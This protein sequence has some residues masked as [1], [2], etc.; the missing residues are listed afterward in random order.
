VVDDELVAFDAVSRRGLL[1]NASAAMVLTSIDGHSP[2]AEVVASLAAD[3]GVAADVLREDVDRAV[4]GF[5][6]W[7]LVEPV[8]PLAPFEVNDAP[9]ST[10]APDEG[11]E[12]GAG[13]V[14]AGAGLV[15]I[16]GSAE[17]VGLD[18]RSWLLVR[19]GLPVGGFDVCLRTDS[20]DVAALLPRFLTGFAVPSSQ[21]SARL[22]AGRPERDLTV[23]Q[24]E[25][26]E[27]F[28]IA[29]DGVVVDE[30][31]NAAAA[32]GAVLYRLDW[33]ASQVED[34]L[35]FH[36][37]AVERDGRV[38]LLAGFSGGGKST[39]TAAVTQRGWRYLSDEVASVD[40]ASLAVYPFPKDLDLGDSGFEQLGVTGGADLGERKRKLPPSE[41]GAV[42]DGGELSL[43]V[44]LDEQPLFAAPGRAGVV[45]L[46]PAEAMVALM[47]LVFEPSLTNDGNLDALAELCERVPVV[48]L[49]RASL[50]AMVDTIEDLLLT[51]LGPVL[52]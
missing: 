42:S 49:G 50:P 51:D 47:P 31:P 39:L 26:G 22:A 43:V 1:L 36:S 2:L 24:P 30:A 34:L 44:L 41:L 21:G 9:S 11:S 16:G 17:L 6:E 52:P 5:V 13:P 7:G 15:P 8:E 37:G 29:V 23:L 20:A 38:V 12:D 32:V 46:R 35:A 27:A 14:P 45:P 40:P 10:T 28:A 4:A 48:R 18:D 33:L 25:G 3:L 19:P